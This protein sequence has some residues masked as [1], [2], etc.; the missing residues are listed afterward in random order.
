MQSAHDVK[1]LSTTVKTLVHDV[2]DF[3]EDLN[4]KPDDTDAPHHMEEFTHEGL[5]EGISRRFTIDREM[6]FDVNWYSP[7]RLFWTMHAR[8]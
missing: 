8:H 5:R 7:S 1:S 4:S 3:V 6:E 2:K